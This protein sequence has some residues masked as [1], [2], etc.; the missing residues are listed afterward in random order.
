MP[1]ILASNIIG[2]AQVLAQDTSAVRWTL[3]EL[4]GW[5]NDGQREIATIRPSAYSKIASVPLVA[6]T[7]QTLPADGLVFVEL[8]R[9]MGVGGATPGQAVRKVSRWLLD[10]HTPSWH[11]QTQSAVVQNYAFEPISPKTFYVYPPSTGTTQ[12]E[13]LYEATPPDIPTSASV[14]SLDDVYANALLDYVLYRMYS[15]DIEFPG[16]AEKAILYRR[17]FENTMGLK[18]QSDA[19]AAAVTKERG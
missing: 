14:I 18:A 17:S 15:K 7:R 6:G 2:K 12:V 13:I 19:A 4:L 16:N 11:S 5:L 8:W 10:S 3:S 1:T 9:N